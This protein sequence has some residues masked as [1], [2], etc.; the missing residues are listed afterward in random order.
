MPSSMSSLLISNFNLFLA[1]GQVT[2]TAVRSYTAQNTQMLKLSSTRSIHKNIPAWSDGTRE[3]E[4]G[5]KQLES[6][7]PVT[8]RHSSK[9]LPG[10]RLVI[11][12]APR[13]SNMY[14]NLTTPRSHT[15]NLLSYLLITANKSCLGTVSL[16]ASWNLAASTSP[17]YY[18]HHLWHIIGLIFIMAHDH[19]LW[20][21][22]SVLT[23]V[24]VYARNT[25][26]IFQFSKTSNYG[27]HVTDRQRNATTHGETLGHN[28]SDLSLTPRRVSWSSYLGCHA[29][30]GGKV[31]PSISKQ[32]VIALET[33]ADQP[34]VHRVISLAETHNNT[35]TLSKNIFCNSI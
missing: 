22:P 29:W 31:V 20:P 15:K 24:V 26:I 18:G 2:P 33:Y 12:L 28:A 25:C 16:Q 6:A 23:A 10:C 27:S 9:N 35:K 8:R 7:S 19:D 5:T 21:W 13:S 11:N 1:D 17:C 34:L 32:T 30:D 4:S 14:L 3:S